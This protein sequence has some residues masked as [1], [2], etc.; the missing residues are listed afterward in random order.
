[1]LPAERGPSAVPKIP[2]AAIA[3]RSGSASNH[4]DT[5]SDDR[6]RRPPQQAVRVL[7]PQTAEA[8]SRHQHP[9]E[10]AVRGALDFR[11]RGGHD[12]ARRS[13]G[14]APSSR[15]IRDTGARQRPKICRCSQPWPP[16]RVPAR[17]CGRLAGEQ[18]DTGPDR[19]AAR[20]CS[21]RRSSLTRA[22]AGRAA[23]ASVEHAEPRMELV[24]NRRAA[25][26][27][28][29]LEHERLQATPREHSGRRQSVV[30]AADEDDVDHLRISSAAFRPGAPMMPPPGC[31][32]DPHM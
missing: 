16:R 7:L 9:P 15:G 25:N 21:A 1:M 30:P 12:A 10:I 2:P 14:F 32:A 26:D 11:R 18:T 29:P 5:K 17:G 13:L 8:A 3:A 23:C 27:R 4:S 31:V 6:H 22:E 19:S 28:T 20:P 24:G